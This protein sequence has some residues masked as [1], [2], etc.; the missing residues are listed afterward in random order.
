MGILVVLGIVTVIVIVL[1]GAGS[2][3]IHKWLNKIGR[4]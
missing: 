1:D 3:V 4:D 2:G